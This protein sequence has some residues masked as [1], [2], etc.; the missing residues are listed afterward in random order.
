MSSSDTPNL[1]GFL[2]YV[3]RNNAA[4]SA[5]ICSQYAGRNMDVE[6]EVADFNAATRR[7]R[8]P[9]RR[10]VEGNDQPFECNDELYRWIWTL[11]LPQHPLC[12]AYLEAHRAR[13]Y[14][15][16]SDIMPVQI[17][18]EAAFEDIWERNSAKH[19]VRHLE[20]HGEPFH[21]RIVCAPVG[22]HGPAVGTPFAGD[23]YRPLRR[24]RPNRAYHTSA[25]AS[26]RN[27]AS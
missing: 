10:P 2:Q 8:F 22:H 18:S 24:Q 5:T 14:A 9:D 13:R 17:W 11:T 19:A 20:K 3:A 15:T 23:A 7:F 16:L 25:C 27:S 4:T 21:S 1:D 26:N 6:W 12:R